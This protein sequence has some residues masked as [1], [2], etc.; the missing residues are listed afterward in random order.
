[1]EL[2]ETRY[3]KWSLR[4]EE[5]LASMKRMEVLADNLGEQLGAVTKEYREIKRQLEE[6]GKHDD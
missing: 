5:L 4:R 2:D 3:K 1:M 6:I